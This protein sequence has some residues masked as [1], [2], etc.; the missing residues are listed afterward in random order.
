MIP[1]DPE[2][3][4]LV[5]GEYVLG[6]LDADQR[7]EVAAA[8]P[9]DAA[10]AAAVRWWEERLLPL[11]AGVVA[12]SPP[13]LVW[14]RIE[15]RITPPEL[16]LWRR[17]AIGLAAIAAA[18]VI[19]IAWPQEPRSVGVLAAGDK[20]AAFLVEG[21]GSALHLT[22]LEPDP[23][24]AGRALELW[25]VPPS[26]APVSLGLLPADGRLRPTRPTAAGMTLAVSLE[27]AGGSPTGVPT[28]PVLYVGV[29]KAD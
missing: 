2:E 10:L 26:G 13:S 25:Q 12:V 15:A 14:K 5:A 29:L 6:V 17:A 21:R 7:R 4:D 3:R 8:L 20:R 19:Y 9:V 11:L 27:P 16:A 28:G 24:P 1:T 18:L 23:V 22:A